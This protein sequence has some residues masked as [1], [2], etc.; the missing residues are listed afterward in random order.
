[1]PI[2]PPAGSRAETPH[3][4][5]LNLSR[6]EIAKILHYVHPIPVGK[7]FTREFLNT[8]HPGWKLG[9][10]MKWFEEAE[11]IS[12]HAMS[13]F[14]VEP[15]VAGLIVFKNKTFEVV[16]MTDDEWAAHLA[17]QAGTDP[18]RREG[19]GR[20]LLPGRSLDLSSEAAIEKTARAIADQLLGDAPPPPSRHRRNRQG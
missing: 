4:V 1:M 14:K 12:G 20:V 3:T 18:L 9:D 17:E 13:S 7:G 11:I 2:T 5:L 16:W 8:N 6:A 15:K 10:L 19:G